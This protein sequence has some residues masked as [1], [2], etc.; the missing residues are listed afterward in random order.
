[1]KCCWYFEY[2]S[3]LELLL[4]DCVLTCVFLSQP[5]VGWIRHVGGG[6][7][8]AVG[9]SGGTDPAVLQEEE[10]C[11][12]VRLEFALRF[13]HW[14]VFLLLYCCD[15]AAFRYLNDISYP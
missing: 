5:A 2:D 7:S 14:S 8:A 12:E 11:C 4:P 1:M 13:H 9:G 3:V 6:G 15:T 10:E